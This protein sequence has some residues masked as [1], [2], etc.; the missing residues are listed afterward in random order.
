[1]NS[2]FVPM[3]ILTKYENTGYPEK[4]YILFSEQRRKQI[5]TFT[6]TLHWI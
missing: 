3:N 4:L 2:I 6:I 5:D 1:M